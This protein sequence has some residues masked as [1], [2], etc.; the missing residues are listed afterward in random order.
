MRLSLSQCAKWMGGEFSDKWDSY[1]SGYSIDTRTLAHDDLFFAIKGEHFDGHAFVTQAKGKG[2]VTAVVA[3]DSKTLNYR[4]G[5]L[6]VVDDPLLA[7]QRLAVKVREHWSGTLVGLTGSAGKTTTKEMTAAVLSSK[8]VVLKSASNLNNHFGVPL[9]LLRLEPEHKFAVIEMGMSNPGE[10][11]L[12]AR[13]A[14]PDWGV[15]TNIGH[16]HEQNF[17]SGIEGVALAKRELIDALSEKTGI[18]FLNADDSRAA[19][20]AL[21][22]HGRKVLAGHATTADVQAVTVEDQG[23]EGVHFTVRAGVEESSVQLKF[24]GAHNA[25]NALLALAVGLEAGVSLQAGAAALATLKPGEKRGELSMRRGARI[26]DDC[27]NS[28]PAALSAM[29]RVLMRL[30]ARRHIL[31]AGEMLELGPNS[32][33]L[34]EAAGKEAAALGVNWVVGVQ[35]AALALAE[36]AARAGTMSLFFAT[37]EEAGA[38]LARE[39]REGDAVLLKGSRGVRLERALEGLR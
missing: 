29:V 16:A 20:F 39:L 35:G 7:L 18:A 17:S 1:V 11:A 8:H 14:K 5:D 36:A 34:H 28:N 23:M 12:L 38:W 27:Y 9:Q 32:G 3:R 2:A 13:M 37:S 15:I 22:W 26:L 33:S 25:S 21:S 19:A 4:S 6:I 24:L 31:I 30:P 10:I